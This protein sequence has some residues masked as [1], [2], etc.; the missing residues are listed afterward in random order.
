VSEPF[1]KAKA[2]ADMSSAEWEALCDGCGK[3]CLQKL[4]DEDTGRVHLTVV[5]CRL[6]DVESCRC[7]NYAKRRKLVAECVGLR[8]DNIGQLMLPSTCAY[9]LLAEGKE[10]PD[11]HPLLT[12]D[13]ESVHEARQ[14][15]RGFAISGKHVHEDDLEDYVVGWTV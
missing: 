2:L 14:S 10:L 13:A 8:P 4:E 1:W 11:W 12:G 15:A 3:C 5:A 6:L 7:T 9:R